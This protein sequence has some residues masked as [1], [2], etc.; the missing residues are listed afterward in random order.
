M[1]R[2]PAPVPQ[3]ASVNPNLAK[4]QPYPFEKLRALYAGVEP[5]PALAPINLSIGEPKHPT[6]EFIKQALIENLAGLAS[7]PPTLGSVALREAIAGWLTRRYGLATIDA[8]TQV[9]PVNGSREALFAFAQTVIDPSRGEPLVLCPNPFYQIYEGSALLAGA[10]PYFINATAARG[11]AANYEAV[12]ASVWQRTQLLYACSPSNPT[13]RVMDIDEWR[14]LFELSDRYGFV[15]AADECYSELYFDEGLPPLGGARGREPARP[16]RFFAAGR[17]LQPVQ[18]LERAG[19]A[20]RLRRRRCGIAQAVPAVPHLSWRRHEPGGAGRERRGLER[21]GPR[22]RKPAALYG[23]VRRDAAV[24][25]GRRW[26]PAGRRR[27]SIY[28]MRT[29]KADAEFARDLHRMK[30]V[31]VLPGSFLARTAHGENP[32]ANYIRIA[33]VAPLRRMRRSDGRIADL[34][35]APDPRL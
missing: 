25:S 35:A 31:Q 20:L 14:R 8:A 33:L 13:G 12:P 30:N 16:R 34:S 4:L 15:I 27:A 21:R 6:P 1:R 3:P 18:A 2:T 32:G 7:Y 17:V 24:S 5:N 9:L 22:A 11:F 29:P 19:D 10:T 28:W 23:E 26:P